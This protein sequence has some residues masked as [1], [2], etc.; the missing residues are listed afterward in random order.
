MQFG[1]VALYELLIASAPAS[2]RVDWRLISVAALG[3]ATFV[4]TRQ[5]V[6]GD[7]L[8]RTYRAVRV[9]M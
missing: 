6:A 5:L 4:A 1:T 8:V 7:Q 9:A 3:V 2:G